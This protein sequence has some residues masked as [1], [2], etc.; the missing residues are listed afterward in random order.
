M[1]QQCDTE[2]MLLALLCFDSTVS[3]CWFFPLVM[4]KLSDLG[5]KHGGGVWEVRKG[6]RE[7][8]GGAK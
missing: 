1:P 5:E 7:E 3:M 8:G 4:K 6:E 2:L